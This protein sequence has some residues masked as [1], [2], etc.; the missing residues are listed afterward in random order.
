MR[1]AVREFV[2]ALLRA[3]PPH[4]RFSAHSGRL[5][6]QVVAADDNTAEAVTGETLF[7]ATFLGAAEALSATRF[8][9]SRTSPLVCVC[10]CVLIRL[11]F[12]VP[13]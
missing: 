12:G 13:R 1:E 8:Q 6:E 4:S 3:A 7:V 10:V 11:R 9:V 5:L 2:G